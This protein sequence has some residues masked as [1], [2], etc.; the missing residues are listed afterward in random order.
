MREMFNH[1]PDVFFFV[2]DTMSRFMA[3]NQAMY[4]R[5]GVRTELELIGSTDA[6]FIALEIAKAYRD[7]DLS[8]IR[9]GKPITNRLELFH[10]EQRQLDWFV[11][12]KLPL[13]NQLGKV[14]GVMGITRRNEKRMHGSEI[15]E[16]NLA[17]EFAHS[18]CNKAA[19]TQDLARAMKVSERQMHRKLREVLGVSPYE[20]LLRN[21]IR[22]AAKD[23]AS[24]N[25]TIIE[26]ALEHGFCDQ[27]AFS[28]QFRKRTGF[29]PRQFRLMQ[30]GW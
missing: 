21:R 5:C 13:H 19:S 1:L 25:K 18:N 26:I 22:S 6:D 15:H 11:T 17:L 14:I 4:L 27:S 28:M 8:V 29:S 10:D 9:S 3:A 16:V 12:T 2:K 20:L 30:G 23:L 24:S 7:D